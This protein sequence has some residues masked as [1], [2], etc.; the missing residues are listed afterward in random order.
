M[1]TEGEGLLAGVDD[2]LSALGPRAFLEAL[3]SLRVPFQ[4]LPPRERADLGRVIAARHGAVQARV[5][6]RLATDPMTVARGQAVEA[7]AT[8]RLAGWGLLDG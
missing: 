2:T 8:T 7:Q 4:G 6:G 3:P 1:L 5:A